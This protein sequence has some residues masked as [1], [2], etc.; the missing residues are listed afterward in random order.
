[1]LHKLEPP[2]EKVI[3][4]DQDEI[5]KLNRVIEH[6]LEKIKEL[7]TE[8]SLLNNDIEMFRNYEEECY[9]LQKQINS[10]ESEK[11]NFKKSLENHNDEWQNKFDELNIKNK[12]KQD[13]ILQ[14]REILEKEKLE[15]YKRI[16]QT[17]TTLGSTIRNLNLNINKVENEKRK[18]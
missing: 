2:K 5:D 6:C 17:Q 10:L 15:S 8:K 9:K 14:M 4:V 3:V 12:N 1:L 18:K 13:Q 16:E 11:L 7:E